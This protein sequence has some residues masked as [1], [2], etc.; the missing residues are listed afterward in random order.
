MTN[1]TNLQNESLNTQTGGF[2]INDTNVQ[3]STQLPGVDA[4]AQHNSYGD[5]GERGYGGNNPFAVSNMD[6][7]GMPRLPLVLQP[8]NN[9]FAGMSLPPPSDPYSG[10]FALHSPPLTMDQMRQ[11]HARDTGWADRS[12]QAHRRTHPGYITNPAPASPPFGAYLTLPR[13]RSPPARAMDLF[14]PAP[15]SAVLF[16]RGSSPIRHPRKTRRNRKSI[17]A[18]SFNGKSPKPKRKSNSKRSTSTATPQSPPLVPDQIPMD[19][20]EVVIAEGRTRKR[21]K[22]KPRKKS[23]RRR[24]KGGK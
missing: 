14:A 22:P 8:Q 1:C 12:L 11:E 23:K 6:T 24:N 7:N 16:N 19:T 15:A 4:G 5:W 9:P 17:R 2:F 3:P 20:R 10:A 13:P 21:R 18:I